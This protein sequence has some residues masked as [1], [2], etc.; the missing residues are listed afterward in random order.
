MPAAKV[1]N[2]H[3]RIGIDIYWNCKPQ[4]GGRKTTMEVVSRQGRPKCRAV[5]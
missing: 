4:S 1:G 2:G 5:Y 3:F